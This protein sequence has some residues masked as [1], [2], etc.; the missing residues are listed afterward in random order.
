MARAYNWS[1]GLGHVP[2]YDTFKFLGL[3]Y[4]WRSGRLR[5]VA[6]SQVDYTVDIPMVESSAQA[7]ERRTTL[8]AK[9]D[10]ISAL[11]GSNPKYER[12]LTAA[13]EGKERASFS[14]CNL[15]CSAGIRLMRLGASRV[16][17]TLSQL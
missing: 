9:K 2:N 11:K 14:L 10:L 16:G 6:F 1:A 12:A 13:E 4:A 17:G 8:Q 5:D 7:S 3:P 15:C